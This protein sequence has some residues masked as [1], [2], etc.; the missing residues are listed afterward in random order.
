MVKVANSR[1]KIEFGWQYWM[2]PQH[3]KFFT[4]A[5]LRRDATLHTLLLQA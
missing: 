4:Q 5:T 1:V 2:Q 3:Y